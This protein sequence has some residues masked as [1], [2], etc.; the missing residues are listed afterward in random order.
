MEIILIVPVS[1]RQSKYQDA[2]SL[3]QLNHYLR[4]QFHVVWWLPQNYSQLVAVHNHLCVYFCHLTHLHPCANNLTS[5]SNQQRHQ[6]RLFL[7]E[8][9]DEF[10]EIGDTSASK[11]LE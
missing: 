3:L 5:I 2:S 9:V 7:G 11:K 8:N 1:Q 4:E 6:M 10:L